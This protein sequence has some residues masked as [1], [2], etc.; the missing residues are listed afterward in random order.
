MKLI[1]FFKIFLDDSTAR[2]NTPNLTKTDQLF[3]NLNL[4]K[5]NGSANIES[6]G[7][8]NNENFMSD[9]KNNSKLQTNDLSSSLILKYPDCFGVYLQI[10]ARIILKARKFDVYNLMNKLYISNEVWNDLLKIYCNYMFNEL[11]KINE[12]ENSECQ[13]NLFL[14]KTDSSSVYLNCQRIM[15]YYKSICVMCQN[16]IHKESTEKN[17]NQD[18]DKKNEWK[19][20]IRKILQSMQYL[21]RCGTNSGLIPRFLN[22]NVQMNSLIISP[23]TEESPEFIIKFNLFKEIFQFVNM[24][25]SFNEHFSCF[26]NDEISS[27]YIRYSYINFVKLYS[28][29]SNH[30]LNEINSKINELRSKVNESVENFEF[31]S[32]RLKKTQEK[33]KGSIE[34]DTCFKTKFKNDLI[35]LYIKCLFAFSLN[36]TDEITKKFYQYRIVEFLTREIDLEFEVRLIIFHFF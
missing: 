25:F 35:K 24:I 13:E 5:L 17:D 26:L 3:S 32:K 15:F 33:E 22:L 16:I 1:S 34:K 20:I 6:Q 36:R 12:K 10:I 9:E 30:E 29:S 28:Y 14:N 27:F 11:L 18:E 19:N 8:Y 2:I 23:E 7:E 21:I 31:P 4:K